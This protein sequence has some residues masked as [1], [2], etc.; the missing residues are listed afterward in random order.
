MEISPVYG[1]IYEK[2]TSHKYYLL[3]L[4]FIFFLILIYYFITWPIVGYDTDLWYHLSGGRYFWENSTIARDAFFSYITPSKSWYDYYWLFQVIVYKIFQWTGYYG[5]VAL[6]C[7]LYFLTTVFICL[8]FIRRYDNRTALLIGLTFFICYPLAITFR[9][10]LVRPHIFSYLF[11]VVFLYILELK[12][13]KIWMLPFLGVLWSNI[14]GI[15]YPVMIL[16]IIAYLAEMYYS[17]FRKNTKQ[18]GNNKKTKWILILTIYSVFF[19]PHVIELIKTP[20]NVAYNNALY[21]QL[22]VAELIPIDFRSIFIFGFLPFSNLIVTMQHILVIS[23]VIFFLICLWKRKLRVSHL[24]LFACSVV[25]LIKYN[26]F[27]FEF[28][29]LSIPTIR[30]GIGLLSNPSENKEGKFYRIIPVAMIVVLIV[31][32]CLTYGSHFKYRPEYPFT[33]SNLPAGVAK[34]LNSIDAHGSVMNEPNTGGYMQWALDSKYKIYMDMQ[35]AVF[36]DRDF[37]FVHN[38]LHDSNTFRLFVRKYNPSFLSVSLNRPYFK[39]IIEMNDQFVPIFFDS[40]ELLYVNKLHYKK[41]ADDYELKAIDPFS[42]MEIKYE[43]QSAKKLSQMFT[44]ASRIHHNDPANYIANHIICSILIV[45]KQYAQAMPY[46]EFIIKHYPDVSHGYAL[47]ADVLFGRVLYEEAVPL[48][49]KALEMGQTSQ[50]ENV[51]HNLHVSYIRLKEYKKA[52]RVL[53]KYINPFHS[54]VNYKEIYDLGMAAAAAGK[55]RD[56]I[57][58]LK[59]AQMKLPPDDIEYT[60]KINDNLKML[61]PENKKIYEQ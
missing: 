24:I 43:D 45:R 19:T 20:F 2:I 48:Y 44:E 36:N 50:S 29:L 8:F 12:R 13:D 52:Y 26:R 16:I 27:I 28:M 18:S 11:I 1:R 30:Y 40:T 54:N 9:E 4:I 34:F 60:K 61:D 41:L 49:K 32:P 10:M 57:N 15:E 3:S 38:A 47:K 46:A 58:F 5:L 37:A 22:Y 51:Y 7:F 21:Q 59:I 35:L 39:E 23:F 17:D 31:V 14:H 53:S 56:A 42:Y 6:R 25:L 33:Q 55:L